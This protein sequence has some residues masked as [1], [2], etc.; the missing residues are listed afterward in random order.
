MLLT[1]LFKRRVVLALALLLVIGSYNEVRGQQQNANADNE[2]IDEEADDPNATDDESSGD[3]SDLS[4][5]D[6]DQDPIVPS[7]VPARPSIDNTDNNNNKIKLSNK[8]NAPVNANSFSAKNQVE[9]DPSVVPSDVNAGTEQE[10]NNAENSNYGEE[11]LSDNTDNDNG[12]DDDDEDDEDEDDADDSLNDENA[13]PDADTAAAATG[14]DA[15]SSTPTSN[16]QQASYQ[17]SRS[18]LLKIITKPGILAGIIGGAIIG[19]LTAILLI[20][21][22]IYRMRKKDEGSYALEETKKPLNAYDYRHCPTKEFY[23]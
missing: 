17:S 22:I 4:D 15:S 23:A 20:M 9:K 11:K 2:L 18:K 13:S 19:I 8:L 10:T 5:E 6:Q 16:E 3:L 7:N 12:D 1:H 14:E 21:F